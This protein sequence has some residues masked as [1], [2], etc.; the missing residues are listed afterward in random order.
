M[1]SGRGEDGRA[2]FTM[3][4]IR[5]QSL[6]DVLS[7][8]LPQ[9]S[10]RPSRGEG[11]C[12]LQP[13]LRLRPLRE[14]ARR[15][16]SRHRKPM[17]VMLGAYGEATTDYVAKVASDPLR[18]A[19]RPT[20]DRRQGWRPH[21]L[22]RG[23][24]RSRRWRPEQ[25]MGTRRRQD[26]RLRARRHPVRRSSPASASP[27]GASSEEV[28]EKIIEGIEA[29]SSVRAPEADIAPSSRRSASARPASPGRSALAR[30]MALR[31]GIEGLPGRR[32]DLESCA[33]RA[34]EKHADAAKARG[35]NQ[36]AHRGQRG[37]R[38]APVRYVRSAARLPRPEQRGRLATLVPAPGPTTKD[39]EGLARAGA[40]VRRNSRAAG[41]SRRASMAHLRNAVSTMRLRRCDTTTFWILLP[42]WM[43]ALAFAAAVVT[44]LRPSLDD[45]VRD[46]RSASPPA[47]SSRPSTAP[48][49]RPTL[50]SRCTPCFL[51]VR[52]LATSDRRHRGVIRRFGP[53]R[54]R[55]CGLPTR[56]ASSG[57]TSSSI[58][59]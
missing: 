36:R 34:R 46:L 55:V 35:D 9:G 7:R 50:C 57:A 58:R 11:S 23:H 42:A 48:I 25:A 44:V 56:C 38:G 45:P 39:P 37:R 18:G 22:R 10:R 21:G 6:A 28:A 31:D 51:L 54:V 53:R 1:T 26:G 49:P 8:S 59:T 33:A 17:N 40:L 24:G 3:Q 15:R 29:R 52:T 43:W 41:I 14:R 5:G 47:R 19:P 12:P 27:S 4:R 2:F 16:A 30:A 32:S 13:A 20:Q